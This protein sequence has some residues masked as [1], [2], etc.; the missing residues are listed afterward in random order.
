MPDLEGPDRR[1]RISP[2]LW[3][4]L[5]G[6]REARG[7]L[8]L[9]AARMRRFLAPH[10]TDDGRITDV[11]ALYRA[12]A[13]EHQVSERQAAEDFRA[14]DAAGMVRC[15]ARSA[16]GRAA[17]YVLTFDVDQVPDVSTLPGDLVAAF[18]RAMGGRPVDDDE[19]QDA[20]EGPAEEHGQGD[21]GQACESVSAPR[22]SGEAP[23]R[24][25][26]GIGRA[27]G[28]ALLADCEVWR[29]GAALS[30][31]HHGGGSSGVLH[32]SPL[33]RE[34]Y[35][36]PRRD[37]AR[38]GTAARDGRSRGTNRIDD[39]GLAGAVLDRC[40]PAWR[41]QRGPGGGLGQ[42]ERDGLQPLV[43]GALRYLP[44][45]DVV[46]ALTDR[47]ASARSLAA[48]VASRARAVIQRGRAARRRA[49]ELADE[50]GAAYAAW[51]TRRAAE[52]AAHRP[53]EA[54]AAEL[55]RFRA[56]H[57]RP[58][59]A[60]GRG[61]RTTAGRDGRHGGHDAQSGPPGGALDRMAEV[62]PGLWEI[63]QAA[64]RAAVELVATTTR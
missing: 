26:C 52:V 55:A 61:W 50:T 6:I 9:G 7:E 25:R 16:P 8:R 24:V 57:H 31:R 12:Y 48:V 53:P 23:R 32:L 62:R 42:V 20:D 34:G 38:R 5:H 15:T 14:A 60:G 18:H 64:A 17:R 51:S 47:V 46:E 44:S 35:P 1:P 30:R 43:A 3:L 63:E 28:D 54:V 2:R 33:T 39:E 58:A 36:H 40:G 19:H 45:A 56:I 10:A 37:Q 41:A 21:G 13:A 29:Y 59:A 4:R 11:R 22:E 49:D 27:R